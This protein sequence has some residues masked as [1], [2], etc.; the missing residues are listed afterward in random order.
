MNTAEK[1]IWMRAQ[2]KLKSHQ[3]ERILNYLAAAGKKLIS[4]RLSF[5]T[6]R[7]RLDVLA[8]EKENLDVMMH[9]LGEGQ[10]QEKGKNGKVARD[11]VRAMVVVLHGGLNGR[12]AS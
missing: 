6:E 10:T 2:S 3:L 12:A 8:K 4:S 7:V 1:F 5:L 11:H 9:V